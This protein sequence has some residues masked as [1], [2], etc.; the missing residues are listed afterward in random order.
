[1]TTFS[2]V[3]SIAVVYAP[4]GNLQRIA[5]QIFTPVLTVYFLAGRTI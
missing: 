5:S 4:V 3:V 2:R 1:M